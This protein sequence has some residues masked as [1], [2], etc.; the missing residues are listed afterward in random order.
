MKEMI[1]K[2]NLITVKNFRSAEDNV[3]RMRKQIMDWEKNVCKRHMCIWQNTVLQNIQRI[4]NTQQTE[5][6]LI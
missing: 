1:D 6:N 3:R 2:L 4:L 5:N